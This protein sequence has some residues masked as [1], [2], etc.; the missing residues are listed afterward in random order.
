MEHAAALLGLTLAQPDDP[1]AQPMREHRRKSRSA[2]RILWSGGEHLMYAPAHQPAA[3]RFVDRRM[4]ERG[5]RPW[6][7]TDTRRALDPRDRTQ[8]RR[9]T[10]K[11]VVHDLF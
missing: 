4:P 2:A 11:D 6:S 8:Q 9:A 1:T 10:R 3:K 7:G 5:R